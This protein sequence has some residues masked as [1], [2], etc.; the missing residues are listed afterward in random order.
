MWIVLNVS[1]KTTLQGATTCLSSLNVSGTLTGTTSTLCTT[2][3][4]LPRLV[5]SGAEFF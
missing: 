4:T 2:A 5:L 1:G 3:E